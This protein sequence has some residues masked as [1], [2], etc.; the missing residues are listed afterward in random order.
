MLPAFP[1]E[2]RQGLST[3]AKSLDWPRKS[4]RCNQHSAAENEC[5]PIPIRSNEVVPTGHR[6]VNGRT[7]SLKKYG[8]SANGMSCITQP[9][10]NRHETILRFHFASE[11]RCLDWVGFA[12]ALENRGKDGADRHRAERKRVHQPTGVV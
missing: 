10:T 3:N 8:E 11:N 1:Y 4:R 5:L 9:F 6:T 2:Y 7:A 12:F